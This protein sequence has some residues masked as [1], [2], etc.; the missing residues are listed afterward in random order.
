MTEGIPLLVVYHKRMPALGTQS[1]S[2]P[3]GPPQQACRSVRD[4]TLVPVIVR[5]LE[6][7]LLELRHLLVEEARRLLQCGEAISLARL[8]SKNV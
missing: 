6:R 8:R 2:S 1:L 7:P 4:E 5:P 3:V